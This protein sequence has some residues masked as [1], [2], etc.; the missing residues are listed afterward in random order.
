L[1]VRFESRVDSSFCFFFFLTVTH[2]F[3]PFGPQIELERTS[4]HCIHTTTYNTHISTRLQFLHSS[5]HTK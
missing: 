5:T 2:S 1:R 4:M 3:I